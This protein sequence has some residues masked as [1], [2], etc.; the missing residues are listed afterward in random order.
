MWTVLPGRSGA[1]GPPAGGG[2]VPPPVPAG[3]HQCPGPARTRVLWT[4]TT[5][6]TPAPATSLSSRERALGGSPGLDGRGPR[7]L[8]RWCA[9]HRWRTLLA[10]LLV[11]AGAVVLLGGGLKTTSN[12]DQLEGDSREAARISA[13]VDFGTRPTENVV[14]TSRAGAIAPAE[15]GPYRPGA[16]RR[17]PR[18]QRDRHSG[19]AGAG[20][21]RPHPRAGRRPRRDQ[22]VG[23]GHGRCREEP[24]DVVGPMLDTTK[25]FAAAHPG[26]QVGQVGPGSIDSEVGRQLDA[27]FQRAEIVSLP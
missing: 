10:G 3:R 12:S 11:L 8:A 19:P 22:R 2:A 9:E 6:T 17:L 18:R 15:A 1:G 21:G 25:R 27:D 24:G 14:V 26:L 13:G 4:M 23:Q 16:R 7:G 20:A 5:T